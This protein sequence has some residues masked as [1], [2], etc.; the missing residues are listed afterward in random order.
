VPMQHL[1]PRFRHL[2]MLMWHAGAI[3]AAVAARPCQCCLQ[4]PL[5]HSPARQ[6]EHGSA[7]DGCAAAGCPSFGALMARCCVWHLPLDLCVWSGWSVGIH[8]GQHGAL[9]VLR[10]RFVATANGPQ[11]IVLPA[12][13]VSV[14]S[15]EIPANGS[16]LIA[17]RGAG[18]CELRDGS[19]LAMAW[20]QAATAPFDLYSEPLVRIHVRLHRDGN[21]QD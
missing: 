14:H 16:P 15:T 21:L 18:E 20:L 9:Q 8:E 1:Q 2:P 7:A 3:P 5:G 17:Q 11:Q 10:T 6:S 13:A 19:S 12:G 4:H